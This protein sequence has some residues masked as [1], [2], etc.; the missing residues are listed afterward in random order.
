MRPGRGARAD[1]SG[2]ARRSRAS[3]ICALADS[4]SRFAPPK[5]NTEQD[6]AAHLL[7]AGVGGHRYAVSLLDGVTGSG[8]TETYFE[9]VAQALRREKQTLILLPEIALTVQFPRPFRRTLR[10]PPRRMAFGPDAKGTPP[11]VARG[12]LRRSTRG[13]G[14]ALGAVPALR[15]A[16]ASSSSMKSTK[17]AYKQEDGAIY[18]ARDMAVVRGRI[19]NCPVVLASATPL[20]RNL[21]QCT[22]GRYAH[23]KLHRRHG[24]AIMPEVR[25]VDMREARE[26]GTF[27]SPPLREALAVTLGAGEQA[28][29]FLNRRGYAR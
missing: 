16:P 21:C 3:R 6:L 27:L 25:L 19:E 26:P 12:A 28:M 4:R 14:S 17:Q 22:G 2:R 8:K 13:G 29:L 7:R 15:R 11:G 9:A 1:R 18:H 20:A 23:L 24:V 5:L 10:R